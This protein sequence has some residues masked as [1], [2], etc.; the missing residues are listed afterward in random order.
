MLLVLEIYLG[1]LIRDGGQD[2]LT[3]VHIPLVMALMGLVV[4]LPLRASRRT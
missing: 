3:A 2:S 4:R 1:G